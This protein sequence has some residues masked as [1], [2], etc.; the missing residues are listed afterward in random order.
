MG[1]LIIHDQILHAETKSCNEIAC[2]TVPQRINLQDFLIF[3]QVCCPAAYILAGRN[4][5]ACASGLLAGFFNCHVS[6]ILN[7]LQ[8]RKGTH[9]SDNKLR[10]Y[11][12]IK[13]LFCPLVLPQNRFPDSIMD[14]STLFVYYLKLLTVSAYLLA[15]PKFIFC[16]KNPVIYF[17]NYNSNINMKFSM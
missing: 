10:D 6:F 15:N 13:L 3:P 12:A 5:A 11:P 16:K 17:N 9:A 7:V 14:I 1:V 2:W 8:L 4:P